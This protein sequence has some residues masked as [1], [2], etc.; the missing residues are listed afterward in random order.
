VLVTRIYRCRVH[1]VGVHRCEAYESTVLYG[2][3]RRSTV[4]YDVCFCTVRY[5]A[6]S[7]VLYGT[8]V[9]MDPLLCPFLD[10]SYALA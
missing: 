4:L 6:Y 2:A 1:T 8:G 3:L 5:G 7:V 9:F 10:P